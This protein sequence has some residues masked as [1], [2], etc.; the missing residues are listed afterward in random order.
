METR[1]A[2]EAAR[3]QR[4]TLHE[5]V[6]VA[7]RCWLTGAAGAVALAVFYAAVI[8]STA[9]TAHLREQAATDWPY[10]SFLILGFGAQVALI[11]E[12]RHRRRAGLVAAAAGAGAG[13]SAL[14]MVAC[15]AH[16]LADLAPI[17]RASGAATFVGAN[18]VP[19]MLAGIAIN[20]LGIAIAGRRLARAGAHTDA[21]GGPLCATHA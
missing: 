13:T 5:T 14:G 3:R 16:H 9:G 20:A 15:C 18:R 10:V 17:V 21:R 1:D 6:P 7:A 4:R 11:A 2:S 12:L 8:A 19:L